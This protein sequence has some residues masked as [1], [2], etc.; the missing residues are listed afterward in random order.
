MVLSARLENEKNYDF[1]DRLLQRALKVAPE[2]P[3]ALHLSGIVAFRLGRRE[4]CLL[5]TSSMNSPLG[6][7]YPADASLG[8][9]TRR[10]RRVA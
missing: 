2:Q 8:S 6:D 9:A 1:A 3:D 5:Y 4:D 10:E 7:R